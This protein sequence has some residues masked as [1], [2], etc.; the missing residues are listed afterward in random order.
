MKGY[1]WVRPVFLIV[2]LHL[3]FHTA[4]PVSAESSEGEGAP[5]DMALIPAGPFLMGGDFDEEHPRHRVLLDAFS[6]DRYEVTNAEYAEYMQETG[7]AEPRYWN[8]SDRFHSGDKFPRH[9]A[10]GM[11]WHEAAAFC[12]W[13]GKRL[14]T[15]A[16]WEKAARGGREGFVFPWG[17][18]PD[19]KR[20]NYEGQGALPVG[21]FPPNDYGLFDMA[22]NVWE[23]VADWFDAQYYQRSPEA[24]PP[25]PESGSEKVLRGGSW[26]DG[27]GPNRVAHRHWYPPKAHYKWLGARCA[28]SVAGARNPR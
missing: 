3:M 23:W 21:N 13:K 25:G 1:A 14:P 12:E 20:A 28:K 2:G 27:V 11:S 9:P 7:A 22:G 8:K 4:P 10:V 5:P 16:E 26:V 15:E 18:M 6:I 24:N 17:D 19:R